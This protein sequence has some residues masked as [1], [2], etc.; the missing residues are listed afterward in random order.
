MTNIL[1]NTKYTIA[2]HVVINIVKYLKDNQFIDNYEG[3]NKGKY[4]VIDDSFLQAW[5]DNNIK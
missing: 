3:T 5:A 4:I 2:Y 1:S